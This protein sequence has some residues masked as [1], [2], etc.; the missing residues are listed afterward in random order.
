ML[1]VK[2]KEASDLCGQYLRRLAVVDKDPDTSKPRDPKHA[3]FMATVES[4]AR[5]VFSPDPDVRREAWRFIERDNPNE[6]LE[7]LGIEPEALRQ[8]ID[9]M[10]K[11]TRTEDLPDATPATP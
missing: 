4:V 3:M 5:D 6:I 7:L 2:R 8:A 9:R 1:K 10:L 11:H